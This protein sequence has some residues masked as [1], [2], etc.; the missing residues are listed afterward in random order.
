MP[1]P[2]RTKL[3]RGF[4]LIELL[5]VIAIIGILASMLL[6]ALARAKEQGRTARCIGNIRQMML[7][8]ILYVGNYDRYP[9]VY[10]RGPDPNYMVDWKDGLK[11][12]LTPNITNSVFQ[13]PSYKHYPPFRS[14]AGLI[15][16]PFSVYAL[17]AQTPYSLSRSPSDATDP[18]SNYAKESDVRVPSQMIAIGDSYLRAEPPPSVVLVGGLHM[19]YISI[20]ERRQSA[21][22]AREQKAVARRHHSIHNLGFCD[23]HVEPI[24]FATLFADNPESRR[25]WNIDNQPH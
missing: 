8:M 6:P 20:T 17:N 24:R 1:C 5:V 15:W 16:V 25:R 12:Y 4:T 10:T 22:F 21:S 2:L 13:C 18:P 3:K 11:P 7:A 19:Q 14:G 9:S 23:G